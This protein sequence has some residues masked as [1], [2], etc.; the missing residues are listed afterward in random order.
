MNTL[1][2]ARIEYPADTEFCTYCR[3]STTGERA[4]RGRWKEIGID[5]PCTLCET[6]CQ[7]AVQLLDTDPDAATRFFAELKACVLMT[8]GKV[9]GSA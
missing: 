9:E 4:L 3:Q 7:H 6:C 5:H 8:Y 1:K 2:E